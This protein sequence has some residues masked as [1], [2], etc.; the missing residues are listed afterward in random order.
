MFWCLFCYTVERTRQIAKLQRM[1]E[2]I[3]IVISSA[4]SIKRCVNRSGDRDSSAP[5]L[6]CSSRRGDVEGK[7]MGVGWISSL[8]L[9][10]GRSSCFPREN[11]NTG[12][13]V[14]G[15]LH[16]R[17]ATSPSS[18][19]GDGFLR[20]ALDGHLQPPGLVATAEALAGSA[21]SS[22]F[23]AP[24]GFV[25]GGGEGDCTAA[26]SSGGQGAGLDCFSNF[27][28]EVMCAICGGLFVI[29]TFFESLIVKCISA[30]EME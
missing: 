13:V 1:E 22:P 11:S 2:E 29:S 12:E 21:V 20:P 18:G 8:S 24:S 3:C 15:V 7:G 4:S 28:I 5:I 19:A 9:Q 30:A 27:L 26:L 23:V 10:Q 16:G 17:R 6:P 14:V 25:P